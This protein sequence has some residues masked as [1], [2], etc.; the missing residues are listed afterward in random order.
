MQ[1]VVY[2][3]TI[4]AVDFNGHSP[5][6]GYKDTDKTG[7][8]IEDLCASSNLTIMQDENSPPTLLHRAHNTLSRPDLT[9]I[10]SDLV[11]NSQVQVLAD[12]G[13]DHRPMLTTISQQ[14]KAYQHQQRSRWNFK[15]ADWAA[16][17]LAPEDK[18]S[19][20]SCINQVNVND[21]EKQLTSIILSSSKKHI[22]RGINKKYKPF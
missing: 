22:P 12:M 3:N 19:T 9:I 1:E 7:R 21:L 15:K 11:Q 20:I 14:G 10:S 4:I 13:S 18:F 17:K 2:Y 16:Y 8:F 5:L 6:W